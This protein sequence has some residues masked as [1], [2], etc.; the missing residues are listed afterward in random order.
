MGK[1]KPSKESLLKGD[2]IASFSVDIKNVTFSARKR[3]VYVLFFR[4]KQLKLNIWLNVVSR[5]ALISIPLGECRP[6]FSSCSQLKQT[7]ITTRLL[8]LIVTH[9]YRRSPKNFYGGWVI[10][11]HS[12]RR[13]SS[14]ANR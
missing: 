10:Q 1:R 2:H 8:P 12:S 7:P 3:L 4:D 6:V 14:S 5:G 11:S 13:S 9:H